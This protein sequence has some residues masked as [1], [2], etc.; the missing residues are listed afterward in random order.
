MKTYTI[1]ALLASVVAGIVIPQHNFTE[2]PSALPKYGEKIP[3]QLLIQVIDN[4]YI[5]L[6]FFLSFF[7]FLG[8]HI[9]R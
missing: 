3:M 4:P 2:A 8:A 5:S 1:P 7:F 6:S 9:F